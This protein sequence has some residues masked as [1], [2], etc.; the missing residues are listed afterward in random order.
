MH[1][2]NLIL[3]MIRLKSEWKYD[4]PLRL[5]IRVPI[6]GS[7]MNLTSF[8]GEAFY[9]IKKVLLLKEAGRMGS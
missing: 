7:G 8:M 1:L 2:A 9:I 4:L 6:S 5:E 3:K